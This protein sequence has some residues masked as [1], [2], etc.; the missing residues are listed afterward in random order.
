MKKNKL[1]G[2][3]IYCLIAALLIFG[4][5]SVLNMAGRRNA[6][7][8]PRYSDIISEF[9]NL[10]VS[11]YELDLGRGTLK[12]ILKDGPQDEVKTYT[13]P[14]VN[15][16]LND[17]NS[18]YTK[19]G[20]MANYRIRYNEAN[21]DDKL[22]EDYIKISDNSFLMNFLPYLLLIGVMVIFTFI[23]MRQTTG[24]GKMNTFSRAN[25]R[26]QTGKKVTFED[27]AGA[28]EEKQELVEIVDFLKS[29]GKYREIGARVPK[30]VLLVGPPGTGKTLLAKAVAGEAGAPFFSISGSD[31]VEMYVGVGASR[32]RD[33]FDQAKKH[34][35][36]IIFIDEI[37]AVGRQRGAGLGGGHDEREQ[38]LN[39][40]L[41]EMD[42]FTENENIIVMAATNRRDI[43]D[44]ALLRPGRF[45]RQVVVSYPDIKGREEILK[46]HT[47]NKNIGPDVDL[48]TIAATTAGFT[49][50][51]LENLVNEAA[52]LAAR[53]N[54]KAVTKADIE[55]AT[56]KVVAGPEKKSRVVTPDEKKLT[57]YHEAGHA[58][59]TYFSP[60]QD[61]VHQ[62]TIIPRGSAGGFTMHVPE[63]DRSF[64]SKTYMEENIVVLLGGR[65]AEKLVL[66]DISTG[67]SNDIERATNVARDMVTRYGFSEKLGPI[68]YGSADHEVF[69][70]RDYSQ[71]KNYSENVA[72]EIDAEI[73]EI[74]ETAYEK[75]KDILTIHRD[76]LERCAQ[77]LMK[78]EK[79]DGPVF[80]KLMAGE[81]SIDGD[82]IDLNSEKSK[83]NEVK[84]EEKSEVKT[85]EKSEAKAEESE[86]KTETDEDQEN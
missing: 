74:I 52:L 33:L 31:F 49:G 46:V 34:T 64:V 4:L 12:Y 50:A 82:E 29:P 27:V 38:T 19:D 51:D 39:Q 1:Q 43:L 86:K 3:I 68:L 7:N 32:V 10:N 60:S 58:I 63:K 66:D 18:G 23:I 25:V 40:L 54:R 69:L 11:A 62:V 2:V 79:I 73:R 47:R 15:V 28:D 53:N 9:D 70:G 42:G 6:A 37:D 85:E 21:P 59:T 76:L 61:K 17:I 14:N 84:A 71:G 8:A 83:Q 44:P 81:I 77:Y 80:Y 41:V 24:G 35:P 20:K 16:F 65:V 13:V 36:S 67:A 56:I 55:E 57:A 78:H 75:A 48:K 45:D 30:G 26:Q 5:V 22:V 72:S